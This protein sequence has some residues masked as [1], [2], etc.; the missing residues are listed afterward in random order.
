MKKTIIISISLIIIIITVVTVK[1]TTIEHEKK[2]IE[3]FNEEYEIYLNKEILGLELTTLI[4]KAINNNEKN[5]IQ[6]DEKGLYLENENSINIFVKLKGSKKVFPMEN[7]YKAG[8]NEF[9]KYFGDSKF[10]IT[11]KEYNKKTG[12]LSKITFEEQ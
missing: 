2:E 12:K 1:I 9:T 7:F 8:I 3:K 4:N 10:K 6:K 11:S 5:E